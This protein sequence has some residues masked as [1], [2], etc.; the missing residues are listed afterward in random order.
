MDNNLSELLQKNHITVNAAEIAF[1]QTLQ[2]ITLETVCKRLNGNPAEKQQWRNRL[3]DIKVPGLFSKQ[4]V[5]SICGYQLDQASYKLMDQWMLAY[6]RKGDC[7]VKYSEEFRNDVKR[8]Q[9][10]RCAICGCELK[11]TDHLDHIYPWSYVGDE[12]NPEENLQLLCAECNLQKS[13]S[14]YYQMRMILKKFN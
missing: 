5:T 8:R 13:N 12:L 11:E 4:L 1:Y 9:N 14:P 6:F 3:G 10:G 2:L 7:R